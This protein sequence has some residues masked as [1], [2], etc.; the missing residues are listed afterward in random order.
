[1]R[2]RNVVQAKR[3]SDKLDE[4]LTRYHNRAADAAEVILQLVALAREVREALSRGQSLSLSD[5]ELAF[6]DA[7]ADHGDV[8]EVMGDT[9]L[10]EI[11][12][13]LVKS[14]RSAVTIDWTEKEAVRAKMR[15]QI[16]RLLRRS[17]YPPD[18]TEGAVVTVIEQAEAVCRDWATEAP[19]MAAEPATSTYTPAPG[20]PPTPAPPREMDGL[21]AEAKRLTDA[22]V[23]GVLQATFD[24]GLIA[25]EPGYEWMPG[26]R[27]LAT[28][29]LAWPSGRVAVVLP[30]QLPT[31][32][33]EQIADAGWKVFSFP[34]EIGALLRA[35]R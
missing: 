24:A 11:A 15:N 5:D 30:E 20:A 18:Q 12:R 13:Q 8:R 3:F 23:H 22:S 21:W 17:G 25:P 29:E 16:R 2:L 10:S 4:A 14:I 7:L 9:T 32:V 35:I 34:F 28:L 33:R 26:K 31:N 19:A 27:V 1:M 6:Y